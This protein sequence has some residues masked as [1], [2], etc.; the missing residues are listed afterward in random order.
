MRLEKQIDQQG[1]HPRPVAIDLVILSPMPLR[2]MLET[3][4]RALAGQSLAIRPQHRMQLAGQH[5][6]DR[7]LPQLVVIVEVLVAQHQAEDALAHQRLDPMLDIT[8]IT[9][10]GEAL[11]KPLHQLDA[12]IDLPQE[13]RTSVRGDVA[14]IETRNHT[15]PLDR[16]KLEQL[17]STLCWHRGDPWTREKSLQHNDSLKV[18]APMHFSCLRNRG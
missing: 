6:K 9:P 3:I 4:E 12:A 13:Q 2:R 18:S 16:F 10:V 15:T 8:S 5:R 14:A 7:V 1:I 17:R 11:R